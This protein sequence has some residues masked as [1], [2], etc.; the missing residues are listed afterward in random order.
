[1]EWDDIKC[2]GWLFLIKV[3]TFWVR[4]WG[5]F[6]WGSLLNKKFLKASS[7]VWGIR[8]EGDKE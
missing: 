2:Q 4:D 8:L 7:S 6:T 1:M 3:F 5:A